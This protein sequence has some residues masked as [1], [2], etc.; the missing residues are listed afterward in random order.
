[1]GRMPLP[2]AAVDREDSGMDS[3]PLLGLENGWDKE[4]LGR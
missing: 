4:F 3:G 1:M 2:P